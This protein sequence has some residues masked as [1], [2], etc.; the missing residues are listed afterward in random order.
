MLRSNRRTQSSCSRVFLEAMEGRVL[1]ST[2]TVTNANDTGSGSFRQAILDANNHGGADVI[3]FKIGSGAKTITP[4]SK[5]PGLSG[6]TVV[7][8]TT[9]PG[10]S[11]KP[12]I[13][14]NG[15]SAGSG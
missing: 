3:N 10:F 4:K 9:Q 13:E 12:L 7:D 14:L 2:Y 5:L 8:A 11:G 15:S 6:P 1:M